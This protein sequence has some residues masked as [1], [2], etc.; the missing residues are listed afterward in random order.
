A[1][2]LATCPEVKLRDP[3]RAVALS[4]KAVHLA[5][6]WAGGLNTLGVAQYRAG[7]W[8]AAS[9]TLEKAIDLRQGE[10]AFNWFFLAMAAEKQGH[11]DLARRHYD[12]A[13][14]W[15]KQNSL[16]VEKNLL[17]AGEL[18]NFQR[19]ADDG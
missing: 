6:N 13:V 4:E 5:P 9:E 17:H 2:L 1:W 7:D 14:E 11:H 3:G 12:W 10:G 16:A 18:R 19:E 8:Q 15:V